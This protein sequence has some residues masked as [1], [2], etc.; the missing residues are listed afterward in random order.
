MS[1]MLLQ[2]TG[3]AYQFLYASYMQISMS[4]TLIWMGVTKSVPT[5][6]A[7]LCVHATLDMSWILING[8]VLVKLIVCAFMVQNVV[9]K[10]HDYC[11]LDT[12]EC[13]S[14]NGGCVQNCH[15]SIGSYTC[16]CNSSY[17]LNS[18]GHSCDGM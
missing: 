4:A 12:N 5:Q 13:G 6:S 7:V 3:R 8:H 11:Y 1:Q 14:N 17:T 9:L 10:S 18:N 15:N 2:N 16:T